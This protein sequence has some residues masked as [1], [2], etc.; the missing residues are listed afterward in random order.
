MIK[1]SGMSSLPIK[2]NYMILLIAIIVSLLN[3]FYYENY[4][5]MLALVFCELVVLLY[6]I[7]R[8]NYTRFLSYFI[9]FLGTSLES[10]A[11]V[12]VENFYGFKNFKV[13]GINIA[14]IVLIFIF[15]VLIK[16]GQL[17]Y[18]FKT[19][20]K[21]LIFI[22][23]A[24]LLTFIGVFIGLFAIL[25]ND[26][27][28]A[29]NMT[30]FSMFINASYM[31]IFVLIEIIVIS[32]IINI[33][34]IKIIE[35]KDTLVALIISTAIT[36]IASLVFKNFGNRGGLDSLQVS[37]LVML[38]TTSIVLPFFTV[39]NR[40]EWLIITLSSVTIFT[41]GIFYN[42]NGKMLIIAALMPI[43]IMT[44]LVK[45][46]KYV[47]ALTIVFFTVSGSIFLFYSLLP[48]IRLINPLFSIKFDQAISILFFWR[49]NWLVNMPDS[50]RIRIAQFL[51]ISIEYMKKPYFL[52]FGKGFM[53]TIRD[54]LNLFGRIDEFSYSIW[55]LN[56]QTFY[57]MHETL[58]TLFLTNGLLGIIFIFKIFIYIMNNL[59]KSP[60]II[61]GGVWFL[62]FYS[63]SVTIS[64]YG[65]TA[66]I[67]GLFDLNKMMILDKSKSY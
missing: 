1:S 15:I 24:T 43:V 53:G 65:V 49:D 41:L 45:K 18:I 40:I 13:A 55:E 17:N 32:T 58:N 27:N 2:I 60:W 9:I 21:L 38:L 6:E 56:N 5:I 31:F 20:G 48:K 25:I 62:L 42:T 7:A 66:L 61:I 52:V 54:H 23:G 34:P 46:K 44:I 22:K 29:T 8:K 10:P 67:I 33:N 11:F 36:M 39:K 30:G 35:L 16:R 3:S 4:I 63:Y 12:G 37:N 26:N 47:E 64:I 28:V 14:A 51:N 19:K 59:Y 57:I 50:P